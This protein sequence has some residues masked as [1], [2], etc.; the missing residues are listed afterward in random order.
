LV[1]NRGQLIEIKLK[2]NEFVKT[3]IYGCTLATA[4]FDGCRIFDG[5]G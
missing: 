5:G 4:Y 1:R 2:I 3:G